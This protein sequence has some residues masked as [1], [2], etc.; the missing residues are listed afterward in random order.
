MGVLSGRYDRSTILILDLL[1]LIAADLISGFTG[2]VRGVAI[3]VM[4][5]AFTWEIPKDFS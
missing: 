5:W 3:G 2:S 1:V 4:L